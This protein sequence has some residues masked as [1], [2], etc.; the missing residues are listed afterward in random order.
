MIEREAERGDRVGKGLG[1][2][3]RSLIPGLCRINSR[4]KRGRAD[5]FERRLERFV[6][7]AANR[8]RQGPLPGRTAEVRLVLELFSKARQV[9]LE[10]ILVA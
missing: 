9:G 7:L 10:L 8:N 2:T 3:Q 4:R 6:T 1:L 5:L